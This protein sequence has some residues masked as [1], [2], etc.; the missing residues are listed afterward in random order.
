MKTHAPL[1]FATILVILTT[2]T[3]AADS[4]WWRLDQE[5]A[6][7]Q[8]AGG[9]PDLQWW[10]AEKTS[11]AISESAP[12]A[13][14][15]RPPTTP[16]VR[17]FDSGNSH[18]GECALLVK[19]NAALFS[20]I[21]QGIT[22]EGFFRTTPVKTK[23]ERQAL[24]SCGEGFADMAWNVFLRDGNPVLAVYRDGDSAPT[25]SVELAEDVRDGD[26]HYIVA[27]ISR[28]SL[29]LAVSMPGGNALEKTSPLPAGLSLRVNSKPLLVGRSSIYIDNNPDYLGTRDTF[30]GQLCDIRITRSNLTDGELL[31]VLSR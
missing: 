18:Q 9:G 8:A 25:A 3:R 16:P 21:G 27:R 1:A 20:D 6:P 29:F 26:W 31:G 28:D 14:L 22:I 10:S 2:P 23:H 4:L 11:P 17:S 5:S 12:P 7:Y 15:Y 19:E 30:G 24:I 13:N